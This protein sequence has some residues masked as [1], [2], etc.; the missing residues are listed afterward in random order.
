MQTRSGQ[1]FKNRASYV[2]QYV[3]AVFE[4]GLKT[5]IHL[6]FRKKT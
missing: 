6:Y 5:V 4:P 2:R 1:N 3:V